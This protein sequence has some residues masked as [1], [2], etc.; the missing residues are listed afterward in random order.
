VVRLASLPHPRLAAVE[1]SE[2][3]SEAVERASEAAETLHKRV[4]WALAVGTAEI[5]ADR[6]LLGQALHEILV[7]AVE[8]SGREAPRVAVALVRRD[9]GVVLTVAMT[10]QAC[11]RICAPCVRSLFYH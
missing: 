9:D 8:F 10:G 2:L 4:D 5:V 3:V 7:N 11:A 6:E 1:L